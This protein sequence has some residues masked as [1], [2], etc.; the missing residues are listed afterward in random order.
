V[1]LVAPEDHAR[2]LRFVSDLMR[3]GLCSAAAL[4]VDWGLLIALVHLGTPYLPA[5]ALS[6]CTGMAIAYFGSITFVFSD[7]RRGGVI[8]EAAGFILVG[9]AGLLCNQAL[10]FFFV[11]W[12]GLPVALAKAP[13]AICVFLFN[14]ILRRS[15]VF[16]AVR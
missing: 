1:D 11:Q 10:L 14:F 9:L 6:F 12:V 15:L 3:Y 7:R 8:A 5:A 2:G 4:G 16:S 13:T